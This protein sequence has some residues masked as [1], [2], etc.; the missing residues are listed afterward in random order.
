MKNFG[1]NVALKGTESMEVIK[2]WEKL[3]EQDLKR[4]QTTLRKQNF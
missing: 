4:S 1:V 3:L 2:A